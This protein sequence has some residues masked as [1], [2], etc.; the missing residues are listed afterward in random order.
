MAA[1]LVVEDDATLRELLAMML[2]DEGLSVETAANGRE[3]LEVMAKDRPRVIL[4]DMGMPIMDGWEFCRE[5]DRR[6]GPRPHVVVVT[7]ASDPATRASEVDADAWLSKP[8]DRA[9][10]LALVHRFSSSTLGR[11]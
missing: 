2:E 11:A 4:L 1:V 5:M 6:G 10:L 3:A 8:F 9:A 7:A